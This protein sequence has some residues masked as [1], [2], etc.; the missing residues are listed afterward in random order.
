MTRPSPASAGRFNGAIGALALAC[1]LLAAAVAAAQTPLPQPDPLS[2]R[3]SRRLDR[4]EQVLREL[5]AIVFQG[6]DTGRP[7]VVQPS[8]TE[9]QMSDLV[10]RVN[11]LEQTLTRLNGALETQGHDLDLARQ[12][13][14]ASRDANEALGRR[15]AA[16]EQQVAVLSAPP[17]APVE[18]TPP[19]PAA[20]PAEAA[21]A[22]FSAARRLLLD[23][24]YGAAE[25]AFNGYLEQYGTVAHGAEARYYLGKT[26]LARRAWPDAASSFI[27]AIRG[28]PQ[29]AWAPD[30][31]LGLSRAL[32]GMQRNT[33][34]CQ[35]LAELNRRYPRASTDVKNRAAALATQ[36]RC[37]AP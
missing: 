2:A 18:P 23:G 4:M 32:V 34:A 21:E 25:A 19:P 6:R 31:V 3:D 12:D 11:S 36:A 28:W 10:E 1:G 16:L 14:R 22:A 24:D 8:E 35:T 30:A 5:R 26:Q 9:Q 29:T 20:N 15:I 17:P 7:V 33:D 13:L 27:A 37:Q